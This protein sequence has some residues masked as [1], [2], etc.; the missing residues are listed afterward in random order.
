MATKKFTDLQLQLRAYKF[1]TVSDWIK[2]D[3]KSYSLAS[4]RGLIKKLSRNMFFRFSSDRKY[5]EEE[6]LFLGPVRILRENQKKRDIRPSP[7][8]VS[9][10]VA[11]LV[12]IDSKK[13]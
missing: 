13:R 12:A 3:K 9:K 8:D 6:I 10:L 5:S 7:I 11:E 2:Y 1:F 4:R